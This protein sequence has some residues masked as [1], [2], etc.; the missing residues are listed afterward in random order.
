MTASSAEGGSQISAQ[1]KQA[2]D[3]FAGFRP[4]EI[5][6]AKVCKDSSVED[7][8]S[9]RVWHGSGGRAI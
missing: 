4:P 2:L 6:G 8:V 1:L 7:D 3:G 9:D 5:V